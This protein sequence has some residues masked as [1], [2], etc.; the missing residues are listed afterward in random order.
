MLP[1]TL[2]VKNILSVRAICSVVMDKVVYETLEP[3]TLSNVFVCPTPTLNDT[4]YIVLV[5]YFANLY[6]S[7]YTSIRAKYTQLHQY[8][9]TPGVY[10]NVNAVLLVLLLLVKSP[11]NAI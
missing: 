7:E 2:S 3:T 8:V 11:Q 1:P 5:V 9:L 6:L 10:R 4:V